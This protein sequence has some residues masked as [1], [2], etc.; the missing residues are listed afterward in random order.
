M[1]TVEHKNALTRQLC[2]SI[3]AFTDSVTKS[4]REHIAVQLIKKY[5]CLKGSFG[6]G[7]VSLFVHCVNFLYQSYTLICRIMFLRLTV[8]CFSDYYQPYMH[9]GLGRII[10]MRVMVDNFQ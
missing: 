2:T 8:A 10:C 9:L 1:L 6:A 5:P 3:H 7:H 4:E